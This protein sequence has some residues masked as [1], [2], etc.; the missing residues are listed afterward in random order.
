M[1]TPATRTTMAPDSNFLNLRAASLPCVKK[2]ESVAVVRE[3]APLPSSVL[4]AKKAPLCSLER[5]EGEVEACAVARGE[6]EISEGQWVNALGLDIGKNKG[7]T[8]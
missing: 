4:E 2:L 7:V 3:L 8:H 1:E 5:A 6:A